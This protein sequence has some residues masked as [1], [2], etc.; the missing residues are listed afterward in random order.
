MSIDT[1]HLFFNKVYCFNLWSAF[2]QVC[3][4]GLTWNRQMGSNQPLYNKIIALLPVLKLWQI[5]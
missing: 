4:I 1:P 5:C 2:N 3:K